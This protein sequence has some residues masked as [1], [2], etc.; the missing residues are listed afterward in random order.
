MKLVARLYKR[1]ADCIKLKYYYWTQFNLTVETGKINDILLII[2]RN[3][4]FFYSEILNINFFVVRFHIGQC[5]ASFIYITEFKPGYKNLSNVKK[6]I[7]WVKFIE[8]R[9]LTPCIFR[10]S[11]NLLHRIKRVNETTVSVIHWF[12][13]VLLLRDWKSRF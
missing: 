12:Q 1:R 7:E 6:F 9:I 5:T 2:L 4:Q 3:K 10:F 8:L 13:Q 11:S